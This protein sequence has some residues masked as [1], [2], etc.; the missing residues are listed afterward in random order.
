MLPQP[1]LLSSLGN[2]GADEGLRGCSV[3]P[4]A[5]TLLRPICIQASRNAPPSDGGMSCRPGTAR[6]WI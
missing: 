4:S 6:C 5:L 3:E 1:Q 2:K